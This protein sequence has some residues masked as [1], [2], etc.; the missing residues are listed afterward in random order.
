MV[1][2]ETR[3]EFLTKAGGLA[4]AAACP[5][6][7]SARSLAEEAYPSKELSWIVHQSPGGL[8]DNTTR[9][10]QPH[11]QSLGF[12]S[13]I[14]YVRGASGRIARA[15]LFRAKPDG[16]SIMTDTIP[17]GAIGEL[18]YNGQYKMAE[19]QPIAGWYFNTFAMI[20]TKTSPFK[21][22]DDFVKAAK[23]RRVTMATIGKGNAGHLQSAILKNLL[24]LNVQFVH[25]D[26]GAPAFAAVVGG[27]VECGITGS[28]GAVGDVV[29]SIAMFNETREPLLPHVPTMKELGHPIPI[30]NQIVYANT[31]P[32]LPADKLA[33][34][35]E[36]F[37]KALTDPTNV[38]QQK[39]VNISIK[40]IPAAEMQTISK[41]AYA[42][43]D[44]YKTE[45]AE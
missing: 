25:F 43:V 28:V 3:R 38:D 22:F 2:F 40:L 32:G 9:V 4:A 33:K 37:T 17:D 45:L 16:Y 7:I 30:V 44:E 8:I 10:L 35:Q 31:S 39:R 15:K 13:T 20:A 42:L 41:T 18:V 29:N 24:K 6:I 14:E 36:A 26:G 1:I 34:L 12:K 19:F 11:L 27:H 23:T 5:A 21:T